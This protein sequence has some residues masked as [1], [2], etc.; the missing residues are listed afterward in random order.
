MFWDVFLMIF[1]A[2]FRTLEPSN[3][4]I[5]SRRN[6]DFLIFGLP[7]SRSKNDSPQSSKKMRFELNFGPTF[8]G[9]WYQNAS[10]NQ[11]EK[12]VD[13]KTGKK[14]F[15]GALREIGLSTAGDI[16]HPNSLL[17]GRGV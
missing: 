13:K 2:D 16:S 10:R 15:P 4:N 1:G 7:K 12:H 8:R 11:V 9:F 5:W 17:G 14:W 6:T 3:M